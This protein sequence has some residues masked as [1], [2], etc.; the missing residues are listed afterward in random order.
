M[1]LRIEF[2]NVKYLIA[3]YLFVSFKKIKAFIKV[4]EVELKRKVATSINV[5]LKLYVERRV[6]MGRT[7]A[8]GV[9]SIYRRD[10]IW[11]CIIS[12]DD[13]VSFYNIY[14]TTYDHVRKRFVK[15]KN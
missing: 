9:R 12:I 8:K 11:C 15:K 3:I 6:R 5:F 10:A 7:K 1:H 14:Y 13:V 2:L 4:S